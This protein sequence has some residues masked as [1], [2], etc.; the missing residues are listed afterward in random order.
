VT[1]QPV[2]PA[3]PVQPETVEPAPGRTFPRSALIAVLGIGLGVAVVLLASSPTW[4]RVSIRASRTDVTLKGSSAAAAA[5]PL[6]LVA[7]AGLIAVALVRNWARRLLGV[8]IA[9]AGIG[10]LIAVIRVIADPNRVARNSS[11]ARSAGAVVSAHLGAPPYLAV[12]GG[13]LIVAGAVVTVL[14]AGTWPGPTSR[15]ERA[16]ARAARPADDWEALDRGEDPT[17]G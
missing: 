13:V 15:Y 10:V 12:L 16:T 7:A 14:R 11:K 5:V 1:E 3:E 6:A 2:P 9:A 17:Q 4:L 8:L